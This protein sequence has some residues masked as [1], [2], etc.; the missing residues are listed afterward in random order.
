LRRTLSVGALV[1]GLDAGL[2]YNEFPMMGKGLTPPLKELFNPHYTQT[3]KPSLV[4][5]IG[6]NMGENPATVQLEHRVI[7]TI[8]FLYIAAVWLK[9][10]RTQLPPRI[11]RPM[12]VVMAMAVL[13]VTLGISTL[14]YMVPKDLAVTHQAGSLMLLTSILVLLGR[15]RVPKFPV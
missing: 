6:H 5:L 10:R 13:Q 14:I 4:S 9:V 1:A 15:F 11:R 12:G 2:I 7:A 3:E 8:T